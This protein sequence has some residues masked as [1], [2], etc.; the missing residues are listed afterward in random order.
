MKKFVLIFFFLIAFHAVSG[1]AYPLTVAPGQQY[2]IDQ[3][4]TPFYMVGDAPQT[5]MVQVST[6]DLETYLADRA[7]RGFNTLW[8]Y[9]VDKTDQTA[10]PNNYYGTPPFDGADFMNEDPTY[11]A[12]VDYEMSRIASY[13]MLAVLDPCFVGLATTD[14][15]LASITNSSDT[16]MLAYGAW[17]GNR[18]KNYTNIIWS[19]GGD[20]DPNVPGLYRKLNDLAVSLQSNAPNQLIT[21]EASRY[22][23]AGGA[24]PNGGYSS[25][26]AAAV[27][28][29]SNNPSWLGLNW[30]YDPYANVQGG[31]STNYWRSGALPALMGEDWYEGEHNMTPL[32]LREESYWECLSGCN[33]G[34][35]FGNNAIWTMGGPEDT[36][37]QTWQSQ[38][39]APGSVAE[40]VLG[41][42]FESREFWLLIPDVNNSVL[43][44]GYQSGTTLAVAATTSDNHTVI[45]YIPTQ[46]TVTMAMTNISGTSAFA[47][48]F[49]LKPAQQRPAEPMSQ[50]DRRHS[51]HPTRMTGFWCWTT[52]LK[53]FL[54]PELANCRKP[55]RSLSSPWVA[56]PLDSRSTVYRIKP[57][58]SNMRLNLALYGRC[59]E[60]A[61]RMS[62]VR[63]RSMPPKLPPAYS[64]ARYI[65][66]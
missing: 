24:A 51:H 65:K 3:A 49:N 10:A 42:L 61:Q 60:A 7:S 14:G 33:L 21:I 27:A 50:V 18:Y 38:L 54:L 31:S 58:A 32:M 5:I 13:G 22:L 30:V 39:G 8:I 15:Y 56:V 4:G 17:L 9:P 19:L 57:I 2:L 26:D 35:I 20:A 46:R 40:S 52:L 47:W 25:M 28:Y 34:R 55:I 66:T 1:P 36:M 53:I 48:W 44:A 63:F 12:L 59:W 6:N 16:T 11:W 62:L 23:S 41:R 29:G 37:G 43:T 45:A 64:F